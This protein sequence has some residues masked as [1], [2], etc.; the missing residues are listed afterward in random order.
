MPRYVEVAVL[1]NVGRNSNSFTYSVPAT[2]AYPVGALVWVPFGNGISQGLLLRDRAD[3]PD[4]QIKQMLGPVT[5]GPVTF[6]AQLALSEWIAS[7]YACSL[8]AAASLLVPPHLRLEASELLRVNLAPPDETLTN[9][10][11]AVLTAVRQQGPLSTSQLR[12]FVTGVPRLPHL[13]NTL[14]EKEQLHRQFQLPAAPTEPKTIRLA[15][16]MELDAETGPPRSPKVQEA[17]QWL[18]ERLPVDDTVSSAQLDDNGGISEQALRALLRFMSD[19]AKLSVTLQE[20]GEPE[21]VPT[22]AGA[23][24]P[25]LT[26][27]QRLIYEEVAGKI[28]NGGYFA[29]LLHGVTGSGKGE[30]YLHLLRQVLERGRQAI[31]LVP[32]IALTPQTIARFAAIYP[33]RVAALH[34]GLTGSEHRREWQR[35]RE[36]KASIVIGSRSA[37]FA[38]VAEPALIIVDEEHE[39]S[40]KQSERDPRYNARDAALKLGRLAA[41]P[42]V[43][44]SATPDVVTYYRARSANE[45]RYY[46]LPSR[47]RSSAASTNRASTADTMPQVQIVDMRH[48]ATRRQFPALGKVLRQRI[49]EALAARQQVLLYLNR[50]GSAT[51]VVCGDCGAVLSCKRCQIPFAW[52]SETDQ[53]VCHRCNRRSAMLNS[54]PECWSRELLSLG[55]GT[56]L[57]QHEVERLFPEARVLRW[58]GDTAKTLPA[59]QR[60]YE[61][62]KRGEGDVLVGTQ[63]IAKG[64]DMPKVGLVGVVSAD[65]GLYLPDYRAA[66]RSY[67]LISQV[68]G[69]AGRAQ[70]TGSV[71]IQ[72]HSPDHYA[73]VAASRH[74]YA[75]F[76][77][78]EL[79]FRRRHRY[80]PYTELCR[81]VYYNSNEDKC[82]TETER[83][84]YLLR[85]QQLE[86][87]GPAPAYMRRIRGRYRWQILLKGRELGP[88]MRDVRLRPGWA[89]D[90]DPISLL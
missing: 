17:Y 33:G 40:Y 56:E 25:E 28:T 48:E 57:L 84:A 22:P 55:M 75:G 6:P 45:L 78:K 46:S 54:C 36:G 26:R 73:V 81:L 41:C 27:A 52:H 69:R 74:D 42:V 4:F 12:Q 47:F 64:L 35:I 58:D 14:I 90:V 44:G 50:R 87:L 66:E 49:R 20:A 86:V 30:I 31:V 32:E 59:H 68:A 1:A 7:H 10:E 60:L 65:T 71:V 88:V 2:D 15:V 19:K 3:E 62:F 18:L 16:T 24:L 39:P 9:D 70:Y 63:M 29:A 61:Q 53:L 5:P 43:L 77:T 89:I 83:V 8:G 85:E 76:Y 80:P 23:Q 37:L 21:P 72:T 11:T 38:P 34:S 51:S 79:A 82:R 13:V 67:Q